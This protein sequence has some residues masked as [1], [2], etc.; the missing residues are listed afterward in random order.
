M[1]KP[2]K[3]ISPSVSPFPSELEV[4]YT[5]IRQILLQAREKA[6]QAVNAEMVQAYWQIGRMIVEHEQQGRQRAEYGA[7][8]IQTL[9]QRLTQ[10]FGKGF[11]TSSL[12]RM[13]QFYLAFQKGA[14]VRHQLSWTHYRILLKVKDE[15]AR[16]FY[17]E[18]AIA[19]R[20]A[21]RE[22]ERQIGVQ[23]YERTRLSQVM[24]KQLVDET[25]ET[26]SPSDLIRDPYY[27]HFLGLEDRP[28]LQERT[29][30]NAI[31]DNLQRFILEL[32]KGF[33][34]VGRQYRIVLDEAEIKKKHHN[35]TIGLILCSEKSK[36]MAQYTLLKDSEQIFAS[37]YRLY[38]PS[39]EELGA[40]LAEASQQLQLEQRLESRLEQA[41]A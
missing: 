18:E 29:L 7:Y 35:P 8:L 27:L 26:S 24:G 14:A 25:Q 36:K 11:N 16:M 22:L 39:E 19:C 6:Y 4:L 37:E 17:V 40:Y 28:G 31:M 15:S 41:D 13:R 20:W 34:F 9:S 5:D 30:E 3:T 38:L 12:K 21:Y 1:A 2:K 23:L 33:A 32:G 10:D